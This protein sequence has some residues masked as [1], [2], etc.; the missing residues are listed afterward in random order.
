MISWRICKGQ[1]RIS[2]IAAVP[3]CC[4]MWRGVAI[5]VKHG[6]TY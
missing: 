5:N 4:L 3:S 6:V 2:L 1:K